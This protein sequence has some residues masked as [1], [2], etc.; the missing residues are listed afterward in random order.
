MNGYIRE[1][2]TESSDDVEKLCIRGWLF[3]VRSWSSRCFTSTSGKFRVGAPVAVEAA[4]DDLIGPDQ[5][6][7]IDSGV[8]ERNPGRFQM[9]QRRWES[10]RKY[11]N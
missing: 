8:V 2:A 4:V 7:G 6:K 11:P 5:L 3:R 1:G 10:W 9:P